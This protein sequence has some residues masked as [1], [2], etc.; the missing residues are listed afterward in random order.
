MKKH[1]ALFAA[2][3]AGGL[4]ASLALCP[5]AHADGV[6]AAAGVE[7]LP[8]GSI[9]TEWQGINGSADTDSAFAINAVIDTDLHPNFAIGFAPHVI[10][11][12]KGENDNG[13]GSTELDLMVRGTGQFPVT[14]RV[15][16]YGYIA[17][18]YSIVFLADKPDAVDN[19]A[20]FVLGF[21]GGAAFRFG[22][23]A[24]VTG[25]LGYQIGYQGTTLHAFGLSTDV[26]AA[27]SYFHLGAG[28][29][30]NF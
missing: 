1:Q 11:G 2:A 12:V 25:E 13:D 28:I 26:D 17:P 10:F 20:G 6:R 9:D 3:I 24:F 8:S 29:G 27:T 19:P 16:V 7:V 30:T 21:G 15:R 5:T 18:G 4:A 14:P 23:K 22:R